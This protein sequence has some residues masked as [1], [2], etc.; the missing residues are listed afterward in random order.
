MNSYNRERNK[1]E[2]LNATKSKFISII[3]HDLKSPISA[4]MQISSF[5]KG[6][7]SQTN[8]A[9]MVKLLGS[10]SDTSHR[11]FN[12][13]EN[14]LEWSSSQSGKM[15]V[16]AEWIDINA[17]IYKN[18]SFLEENITHKSIEIEKKLTNECHANADSNMINT[19]IRNLL[20][21]AV[22]YTLFSGKIIVSSSSNSEYVKLSI[23]DNGVGIN[24]TN[25]E[26]LFDIEANICTRG[27]N[28]ESG[29]GLGL[30]LCKEFVEKN[31]GKITVIS[32]IGKGS[33]FKVQLPKAR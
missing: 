25:V 9:E 4:I 24:K 31:N 1:V 20:S 30:K 8:K 15:T 23:K 26:K 18:L 32:E 11:T 14:L 21:N 33:E 5:L 22:K 10:I 16:N 6:N 2:D 7:Y 29:T 13:L 3:A 19:V 17:L 28:N 12:L 27:T